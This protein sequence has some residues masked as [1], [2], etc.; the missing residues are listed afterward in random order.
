[1]SGQNISTWDLATPRRPSLDDFEGA[2]KQNDDDFPP[3]PEKDPTAEEYN[4]LCQLVVG[5]GRMI[6]NAI[7]CVAGGATPSVAGF[8]AMPIAVITSTFTVTRN[9]AGDVSITWPA[10]TFPTPICRPRAYLNAGPGMPH[11]VAITNGVRVHT[12]NSSGVA[13]DLDFS[14]DVF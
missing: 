11:A 13:T 9:G 2:E 7:V 8:S 6:P 10:N 3:D 1:M 4:E 5:F 14:V 12:Y